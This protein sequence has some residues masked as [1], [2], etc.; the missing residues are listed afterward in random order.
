MHE[1]DKAMSRS[2]MLVADAQIVLQALS[3]SLHNMPASGDEA[4]LHLSDLSGLFSAFGLKSEADLLRQLSTRLAQ[5]SGDGAQQMLLL[6]PDLLAIQAAMVADNGLDLSAAR[7]A[8][9]ASVRFLSEPPPAVLPALQPQDPAL[10]PVNAAPPAPMVA[11]EL[12]YASPMPP[13]TVPI[14][15]AAAAP[16]LTT[17]TVP[18]TPLFSAGLLATP[19]A[20]PAASP[21][22]ATAP[23]LPSLPDW[24]E[25]RAQA[26]QV[27]QD[28]SQSLQTPGTGMP[29]RAE[30]AFKLSAASD[31]LSRIGQLPLQ[32]LYPESALSPSLWVDM[33]VAQLLEQLHV[34]S[35]RCTRIS[36][37]QR[38]QTLFLHWHGLNLSNTESEFLGQKLAQAMG[39]VETNDQG[40]Q[41]VLP[42]SLERMRLVSYRQDDQWCAVSSAQF[43][44]WERNADN[45]SPQMKLCAGF[46]TLWLPIQ[47]TGE[48]STMNVYPWPSAVPSEADVAGLAIDR[49]GQLHI[50]HHVTA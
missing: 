27:L 30:M 42:T 40:L 14:A 9:A 21:S 24:S 7:K 5:E 18:S 10:A 3:R 31:A 2:A 38:N 50:L 43:M 12:A 33:S 39:R 32:H 15:P 23:S 28:V 11:H 35:A 6:M 48:S 20:S 37:Q 49:A 17:N 46:Q 13:I 29:E 45:G 25:L 22:G 1:Q 44:G 4:L 19:F 34:F 8:L 41:L 47:E 16:S 36:A 26:W